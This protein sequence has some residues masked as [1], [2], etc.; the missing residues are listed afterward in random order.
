MF[1]EGTTQRR[2]YNIYF[3]RYDAFA[4]GHRGCVYVIQFATSLYFITL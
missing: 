4:K 2:F 3:V 1:S